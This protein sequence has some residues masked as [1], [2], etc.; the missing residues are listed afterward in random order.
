MRE[1]IILNLIDKLTGPNEETS[2]VADTSLCG[3]WIGNHV[4]VRTYTAG[5]WFGILDQKQ[6]SE[7]ILT[8]A[9]RMWRWQTKKSVSLSSVALHGIDESKSKICEAVEQVWLEA[10]EIMPVTI[11]AQISI[12]GAE[13]VKTD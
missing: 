5:V 6:N 4:I 12:G 3:N 10:I 7:V 1:K 11:E 9:R 8:S 2:K 13:S